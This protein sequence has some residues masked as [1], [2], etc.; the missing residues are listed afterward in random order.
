MQDDDRE[1]N[2]SRGAMKMLRDDGYTGFAV[3]DFLNVPTIT[4]DECKKSATGGR[5]MLLYNMSLLKPSIRIKLNPERE[6]STSCWQISI[7]PGDESD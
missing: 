3:W 2:K 7:L 5:D 4:D 1:D 6:P